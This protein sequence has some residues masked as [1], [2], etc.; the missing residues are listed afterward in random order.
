MA[1]VEIELLGHEGDDVRLRDG[2]AAVDGERDVLIGV[3][4]KGGVDE[5]LARHAL[6]GAQHPRIAD[7][8]APAPHDPADSGRLTRHGERS[9]RGDDSFEYPAIV[10]FS[11]NER[12]AY[13]PSAAASVSSASS[14]VKSSCS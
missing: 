2:L 12:K 10:N 4:G 1:V 5:H 3:V 13:S 7:A 9:H 6:D 8:A 11:L 14:S